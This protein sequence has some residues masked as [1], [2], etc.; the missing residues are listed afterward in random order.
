M[1]G[2]EGLCGQGA[3]VLAVFEHSL[4]AQTDWICRAGHDGKMRQIP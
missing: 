1:F 3:I 2:A 4:V